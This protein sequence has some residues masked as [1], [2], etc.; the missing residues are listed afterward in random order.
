MKTG[1]Q[2]FQVRSAIP[3]DVPALL[4]LKRELAIAEGS[5]VAH[6]ATEADW[7]RDGFGERRRFAAFVAE[8]TAQAVGMVTCSERYYTGWAGSTL[9]VQDIYVEPSY[10]RC[11]AGRALLC[12][13]A[14][15]AAEQGN[16]FIEL[17]VAESNPARRFYR[18]LGFERVLDCM[19]YV[20][21]GEALAKLAEGAR[22]RPRFPTIAAIGDAKAKVQ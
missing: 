14:A 7:L 5:E 8:Q 17:T 4:R 13:V 9:Y 19:N 1:V 3:A 20:A 2:S 15:L 22:D 6:R 21:A 10:R 11:G 12:C 18:R 16:L